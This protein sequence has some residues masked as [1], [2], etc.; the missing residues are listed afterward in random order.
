MKCDE[1]ERLLI[2]YIDDEISKE[3]K[4]DVESHITSCANCKALMEQYMKLKKTSSEISFTK[5]SDE[6]M[7]SYWANISSRLS[8]GG[9]WIFLIIG[10]VI[11]II[12][13]IYRFAIDPS[14]HSLVKVT[15]A[16]IVIGIVLL[17]ISVLLER[18][19]DLKTDRYRGIE[20]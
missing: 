6:T 4:E 8:R 9:G 16:A 10:S 14:V 18:I 11:L 3:E 15:I 1:I 17:F 5:P 20:K 19:R 13:A 7:D 12:Y 2:L